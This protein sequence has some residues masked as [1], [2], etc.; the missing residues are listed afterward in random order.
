MQHFI[1][2]KEVSLNSIQK[3]NEKNFMCKIY[4][5]GWGAEEH[6]LQKPERNGRG[7]AKH[8]QKLTLWRKV[9]EG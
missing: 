6:S 9:C 4:V 5:L 3:T 2:L 8:E 1:V 7:V